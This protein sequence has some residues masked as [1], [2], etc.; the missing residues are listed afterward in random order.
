MVTESSIDAAGRQKMKKTRPQN[1]SASH[2]LPQGQKVKPKSSFQKKCPKCGGDH[3]R[4]QTCPAQGKTCLKCQKPNHFAKQCR[5][6]RQVHHV[7]QEESESGSEYDEELYIGS[8]TK[9]KA[10]T[11]QVFNYT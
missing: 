5:T 10:E 11:D 3:T 7:I 9:T 8:V 6:P 1:H 2:S 4:K